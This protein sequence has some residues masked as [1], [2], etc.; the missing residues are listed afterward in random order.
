MPFSVSF[1]LETLDALLSAALLFRRY[2]IFYVLVSSPES[3]TVWTTAG[4]PYASC[5]YAVYAV[6]P[7]CSP[8]I[9]CPAFNNLSFLH[10]CETALS[11]YGYCDFLCRTM[12]HASAVPAP[13]P[14]LLI[15]LQVAMLTMQ[16]GH[17][18][19]SWLP[20]LCSLQHAALRSFFSFGFDSWLAVSS[21]APA[22]PMHAVAATT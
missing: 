12:A 18:R 11:S 8:P 16:L 3:W 9:L 2:F 19:T 13:W 20:L 4:W 6:H 7:Q 5:K 21:D 15:P 14:P 17:Q 1:S 22:S 10:G